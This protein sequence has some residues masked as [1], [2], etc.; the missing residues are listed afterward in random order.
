[1]WYVYTTDHYS[2]M[3]KSEIIPF[4]AT[5]IDLEI[6]ILNEVSRTEEEKY[7][8]TSLICEI[9]KEMM[10]MKLL[11]NKKRLIDL[12]NEFMVAGHGIVRESGTDMCTPLY[13]KWITN[14]ALLC[15]T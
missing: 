4:A 12:E 13:L 2:V 1:M 5:L 10:Q 6:V 15:S 7:C 8:M 9:Q 3:T 11:T 14:K